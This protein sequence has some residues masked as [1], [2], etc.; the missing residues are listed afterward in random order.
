MNP[1]YQDN[2]YSSQN[3]GNYFSIQNSVGTSGWENLSYWTHTPAGFCSQITLDGATSVTLNNN[4][5]YTT[6]VYIKNPYFNA[7]FENN[8]IYDIRYMLK[9]I[10]TPDFANWQ[11]LSWGLT[12]TISNNNIIANFPRGNG[13]WQDEAIDFDVEGFTQ[14][15]M[16]YARSLLISENNINTSINGS[17]VWQ[18]GWLGIKLGKGSNGNLLF[19]TMNNIGTGIFQEGIR[20]STAYICSNVVDQCCPGSGLGIVEDGG[21]GTTKLNSLH[22]NNIGYKAQ[23]SDQSTLLRNFLLDNTV[24]SEFIDASLTRLNG[25]HNQ[26]ESLAGMNEFN[27]NVNLDGINGSIAQMWIVSTI[28]ATFPQP[29][30]G[31]ISSGTDD[32]TWGQNKITSNQTLQGNIVHIKY[33][34]LTATEILSNSVQL[35]DWSPALI[36]SASAIIPGTGAGADQMVVNLD[37][38]NEANKTAAL[39]N[40]ICDQSQEKIGGKNS[41]TLSISNKPCTF[42]NPSQD[43]SLYLY[44]RAYCMDGI[45]GRSSLDTFRLYVERHPFATHY[46][47]EVI[48]AIGSTLGEVAQ[49]SH[50]QKNDFIENYNWLIRVQPLNMEAQYQFTIMTTLAGTLNPIDLNEAANMWYNISLLFPDTGTVS[51]CWREIRSIRN[52][53]KDIPQDTTPF[54]KLTFPLQPIQG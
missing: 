54:H 4:K 26:I 52:Y 8:Q 39:L 7:N 51:G 19:N 42:C 38:F 44:I 27:N 21:R 13:S 53:Q 37:H 49:L 46:P 41:G 33:S 30:I 12:S 10:L 29:L 20:Q 36:T 34:G 18:G 5:F 1:N 50:A 31:L 28:N 24:G 15:G 16:D 23:G 3:Q 6:F 17:P 32:G 22:F 48:S 40:L 2:N 11:N 47:G 9:L 14:V 45:D 43:D 25:L 35:N